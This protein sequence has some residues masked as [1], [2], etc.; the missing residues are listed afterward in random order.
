MPKIFAF[1]L[2]L[3]NKFDLAI[4]FEGSIALKFIKNGQRK[5]LHIPYKFHI[6]TIMFEK[7]NFFLKFFSSL[8]TTPLFSL[9]AP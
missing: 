9:T 7:N 4:T 1:A 8:T 2:L 6:D 3:Q 5:I